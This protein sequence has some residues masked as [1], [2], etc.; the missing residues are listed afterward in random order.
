MTLEEWSYYVGL[1][2]RHKEL[3]KLAGWQGIHIPEER[4]KDRG[5][6][7]HRKSRRLRK[8]GKL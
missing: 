3:H 1:K 4:K 6:L 5:E 7:I 2:H 8:E